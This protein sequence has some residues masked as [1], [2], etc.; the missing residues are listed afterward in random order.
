VKATL[1][2]AVDALVRAFGEPPPPPVTDPFELTVYEACAYLV[3]DDRRLAVFRRLAKDVGITPGKLFAAGPARI[4]RAIADGGMKPAMRAEKVLECAEIASGAS[5]LAA[6][7]RLP[8][9][10]ARR[11]FQRFP[12]LGRPGAEK[13]LLFCGAHAVLALDS[14]GL[15]V[16]VRLGFAPESKDYAKTYRA[17]RAA[18]EPDVPDDV[19]WVVRAHQALRRHGQ[20]V[21]RRTSPACDRC[22]LEPRCAFAS[23]R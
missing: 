7:A 6:A 21:C 3:D 8:L 1:R 12:G 20:D 5:D 14:N 11:V 15:R 19:A 17:V 16:L 4:A 18:V 9:D 2:E 23:A 22:P 10:E 13:V